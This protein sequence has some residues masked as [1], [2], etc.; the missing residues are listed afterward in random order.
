MKNKN[1]L[2][3]K[4]FKQILNTYLPKSNVKELFEMLNEDVSLKINS[5]GELT[6]TEKMHLDY[7]FPKGI[8]YR[9]TIDKVLTFC[10]NI[11]PEEKT[12]NLLL[13]LSQLMFFSGEI[14]Y[15]LELAE[16]LLSKI[17]SVEKYPNIVA[18][19]NLMISKIYWSQA[20]WDDCN[21]YINEAM[22]IFQSVNNETG[23]AKCHNMLG[24]LYGEKGEFDKARDHLKNALKYL[25]KKDDSSAR[26]M[27]YTNLGILSTVNEEYEKAIWNH[28]NALGIFNKLGDI[29]RV[30]RVHHNIGMLYTR[31]ENYDAALDEFNNCITLSLENDYL[32]NCAVAYIGKS[33]VYTQVKNPALADAYTEKAMEIA[34][35]LNDTLSIADIYKIKGMIQNDMKNFE[36]SE[37]MFENSIRLNRDIQSKLNE[38]ESSVQ[39]GEFL[40]KN[41]RAEEAKPYLQ[42]AANF[43][44][45]LKNEKITAG[46]VA[47]NI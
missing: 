13:D 47:Q 29:R 14:S 24:T 32:S 33:F 6:E 20:Y 36:L 23:I 39:L 19:T 35:K 41:N 9:I 1:K 18:E 4:E 12:F 43:F 25:S 22:R 11:L 44:N 38:A 2:S 45:G 8:D 15:S 27:I 26:A 40:Q 30:A 3:L 34:Y 7:E 42:T 10:T 17:N 5:E 28:K 31:M 46:L 16:D 21:H 37:E